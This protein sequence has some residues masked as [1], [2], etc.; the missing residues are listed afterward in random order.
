MKK[1]YG[2]VLFEYDCQILILHFT[3]DGSPPAAD[4]SSTASELC[5][6]EKQQRAQKCNQRNATPIPGS[7]ASLTVRISLENRRRSV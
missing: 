7:R 2:Y 4:E 3:G 1:L 6:A 5:E